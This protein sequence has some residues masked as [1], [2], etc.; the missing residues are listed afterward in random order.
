MFSE[1]FFSKNKL[2]LKIKGKRIKRE[3]HWIS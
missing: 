1:G 2:T 3:K